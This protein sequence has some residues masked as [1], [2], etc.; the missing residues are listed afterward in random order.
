MRWPVRR[1]GARSLRLPQSVWHPTRGE[2]REPAEEGGG[3]GRTAE[4]SRDEQRRQDED[5]AEERDPPVLPLGTGD[6][7]VDRIPGPPR[8]TGKRIGDEQQECPDLGRVAD[9]GGQEAVQR[10]RRAAEKE[11][12][13]TVRERGEEGG[14]RPE[15]EPDEVRQGE[16]EAEEDRQARAPSVVG[17][18]DAHRVLG[19]CPRR[20]CALRVGGRV[21][22]GQE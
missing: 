18:F 11:G 4:R 15:G 22:I 9:I 17:E 7:R 6:H 1:S 20:S 16:Q 3:E 5:E 13:E 19:K 12:H 8:E 21:A 14:N 2:G 10:F